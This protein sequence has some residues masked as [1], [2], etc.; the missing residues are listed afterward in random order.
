MKQNQESEAPTKNN[1][2]RNPNLIRKQKEYT[3]STKNSKKQNSQHNKINLN[4]I[5]IKNSRTNDKHQTNN[6]KQFSNNT[7]THNTIKSY[8]NIIN[9]KYPPKQDPTN[10][11]IMKQKKMNAEKY[12]SNI[13]RDCST[14]IQRLRKHRIN[15]SNISIEN[16]YNSKQ[17]NT[18]YQQDNHTTTTKVI[19]KRNY[20]MNT[21]MNTI[22]STTKSTLALNN[23]RIKTKETNLNSR[24]NPIQRQKDNP[25]ESK[26][27]TNT[28]KTIKNPESSSK[29]CHLDSNGNPTK[30]NT[31]IQRK[32]TSE[33]Q[34][35]D[36][37]K[38]TTTTTRIR[39]ISKQKQIKKQNIIERTGKVR[40]RK[41]TSTVG[42]NT[43]KFYRS[44]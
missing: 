23:K 43:N 39:Y 22:N 17:N 44:K 21:K 14:Y 40:K 33:S 42:S 9:K 29:V 16:P 26:N 4:P 10:T 28:K 6:M 18:N 3:G 20:D 36:S 7:N 32:T 38:I 2:K 27:K 35:R 41:K 13:P 30:N 19:E 11:N 15:K 25:T 1:I 37:I 8:E 31:I 24:N 34:K 5:Q 12:T